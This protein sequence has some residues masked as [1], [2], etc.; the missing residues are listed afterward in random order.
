M[1]LEYRQE[2]IAYVPGL[3]TSKSWRASGSSLS[4]SLSERQPPPEHRT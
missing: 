3:P 2:L 4:A 1:A